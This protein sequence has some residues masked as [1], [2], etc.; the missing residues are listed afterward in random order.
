MK[1][2]RKLTA[3]FKAKVVLDSLQE[4]ENVT[5]LS[6]KYTLASE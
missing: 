4:R 6:K 3:E 1:S 2:K 5:E